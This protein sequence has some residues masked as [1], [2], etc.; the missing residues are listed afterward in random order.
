MPRLTKRIRTRS[1][2]LTSIGVVAGPALPLIVSQLNS[3]D[4][5]LGIVLFGSSAHSC[6]EIRSRDRPAACTG[7]SGWMMK[8]A[9]H[10]HHFL[11]R[12]CASGR[13]TCRADAA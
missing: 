10:P 8:Q 7:S 6:N 13:R 1:P 12:A 9:D 2:S 11:H 3:I 5:V 4:S